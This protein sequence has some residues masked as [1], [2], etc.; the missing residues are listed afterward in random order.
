M[1]KGEPLR[2]IKGH[3]TG[4]GGIP[5]AERLL[6]YI[7]VAASG[8][9]LWLGAT[10]ARY[11]AITVEGKVLRAHRAAYSAFIGEIPHGLL[12]L[13]RCD[14]PLCINP[15]HLFLGTGKT[16][17]DDKVSKGR[18]ARGETSGRRILDT[19]RVLAIREYE[20]SHSY[21]ET[22]DAF[23][24]SKGTVADIINGRT[25]THI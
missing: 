25:W 15:T 8:C 4:V 6:A 10:R 9:W 12:V 7:E 11:G 19:E 1:V 23:S 18:Q 17:T 5:L 3:N 14:T 2:Y 22:A 24:V 21:Q 13:H 20:A 16:N